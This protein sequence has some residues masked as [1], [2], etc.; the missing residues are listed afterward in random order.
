MY[1]DD[2]TSGHE[3]AEPAHEIDDPELSDEALDRAAGKGGFT[4]P[5]A[6][7]TARRLVA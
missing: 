2:E 5:C 3:P 7:A 6:S 4:S 1:L